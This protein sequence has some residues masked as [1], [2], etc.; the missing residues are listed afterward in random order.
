MSV[1]EI[2]RKR[3]SIRSYQS[4]SIP[5]EVMEKVLEAGRLAQ[6]AGNRQPW[7]FIV[8]EGEELKKELAKACNNQAFVGEAASVLVCVVDPENCGHVGAMDSFLVDAAIAVENMA[9]V[10]WENGVGSCWIG[11][12]DEKR[13]KK[14]LNIPRELKVASILTLGYPAEEPSFKERKKLD[15]IVHHE[16]YKTDF[17]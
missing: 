14:L 16:K 13:I 11:A 8:V 3:G 15:Q 1:L 7:E 6:S 5:E 4:K 10:S 12:Y 17:P 9:L 2:I